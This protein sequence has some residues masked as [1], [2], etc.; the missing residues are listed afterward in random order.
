MIS[1]TPKKNTKLLMAEMVC[2]QQQ[3]GRMGQKADDRKNE[4]RLRQAVWKGGKGE[5]VDEGDNR[6]WC[7]LNRVCCVLTLTLVNYNRS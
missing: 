7:N 5:S 4:S 2:T 6:S 3:K 1:Q